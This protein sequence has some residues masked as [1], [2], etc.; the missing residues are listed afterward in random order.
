MRSLKDNSGIT[1]VLVNSQYPN[2]A[3]INETDSIDG[4]AVI[5]EIYNDILVNNYKILEAAGIETNAEA[6]NEDN[7]YQLLE[8]HQK[9]TNILNDIEQPIVLASTIWS[10]PIA[11]DLLPNKYVLVCKA[12]GA[13]NPAITY[14][15]KGTGALSYGFTS[16]TGF[17]DGDELVVIISNAGVKAYSVGG[18]SI[19]SGKLIFNASNL[20]GSDPSFY[21]P[22]SSTAVPTMPKYLTMYIQNGDGDNQ[23]KMIQPVP[24]IVDTRIITGM[25]SPT[26][27]PDAVITLFFS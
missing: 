15:F 7:G 23:T 2:G 5:N 6:D 10:I 9:L 18:G 3:I 1:N 19:A 24:Y 13:Y 25:P 22:L 26:D 11:I 21:L 17:N 8:A 4:T 16:P 14:T 12:T 27:W 20:L